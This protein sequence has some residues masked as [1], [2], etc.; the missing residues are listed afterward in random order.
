M[1]TTARPLWH[2]YVRKG[3]AIVPTVAQ[4]DAG[5]FLDS[6]PVHV[7]SLDSSDLLI[8]AL[9]RVMAVGNPVVATPTRAAFPKPVVLLYAKVRSWRT[10]E[11]TTTCFSVSRVGGEFELSATGR[12]ARGQWTES[13]GD[14]VRIPVSGGAAGLAALILSH[15]SGARETS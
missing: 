14:T 12:D 7:S 3:M 5:Y 10:F 4:T 1:R 2:V 8:E 11:R 13:A 6:E 9:E 15:T